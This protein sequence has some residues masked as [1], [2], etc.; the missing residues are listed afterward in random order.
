MLLKGGVAIPSTLPLDAPL[1]RLSTAFSSLRLLG[2]PV[3]WPISNKN[4]ATSFSFYILAAPCFFVFVFLKKRY[5]KSLTFHFR[6]I[7]HDS[8]YNA[9]LG[10]KPVPPCVIQK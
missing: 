2:A 4:A 5:Y 3:T 1:K 7:R 6:V 10:I 8:L 9:H